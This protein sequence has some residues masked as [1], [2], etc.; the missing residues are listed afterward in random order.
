MKSCTPAKGFVFWLYDPESAELTYYD[1]EGERD[2]DATSLIDS[3][4]DESWS[5]LTDQIS[6]GTVTHF[7]Q[8]IDKEMRPEDLDP[9]DDKDMCEW[10]DGMDW[11]GM[12]SME[13]V[14]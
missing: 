11:R 2:S 7:A 14:E 8:V 1:H 4:L 12:Y 10:P 3:Y 9:E 13:P 6:M 5:D